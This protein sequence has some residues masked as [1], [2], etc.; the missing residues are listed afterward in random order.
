MKQLLVLSVLGIIL[1]SGCTIPTMT[2]TTMTSMSSSS[3]SSSSATTTASSS[4]ASVLIQ[5]FAFMPK[6]LTVRVGTIVTWTNQD[7][8]SHTVTSD[9]G[10]ELNSAHIAPGQTYSHTFAQ[11]GTFLYHCAIHPSMTATVVVTQ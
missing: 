4:S 11:A 10:S 8:T 1:L 3:S 5:N 9:S 6:S 2:S 7:S